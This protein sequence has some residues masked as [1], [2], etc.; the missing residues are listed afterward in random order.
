M[1]RYIDFTT[2]DAVKDVL[3]LLQA[4]TA[5]IGNTGVIQEYSRPV[6]SELEDIIVGAIDID[7]NTL[8]HCTV[9]VNIHVKDLSRKVDTVTDYKP[10]SA[11]L[12]ALTKKLTP[13]LDGVV[14]AGH[15][16][17]V[18]AFIAGPLLQGDIHQSYMNLRL[19]LRQT[20][21]S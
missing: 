12:N 2:D 11:R 3:A 5:D 13:L 4:H 1:S 16:F 10:N 14:I 19:E 21:K 9:N 18:V 20:T 15:W 8:Q 6:N 17:S 7:S